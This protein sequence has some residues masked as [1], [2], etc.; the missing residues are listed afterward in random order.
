MKRSYLYVFYCTKANMPFDNETFHLGLFIMKPGT[1]TCIMRVPQCPSISQNW[2][3]HASVCYS[4]VITVPTP[5]QNGRH[6]KDIFKL[7]LSYENWCIFIW[8]SFKFISKAINNEQI[9]VHIINWRMA[10]RHVIIWSYILK[11]FT[12][13]VNIDSNFIEVWS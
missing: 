10:G 4:R 1:L 6:F 12:K 9:L 7:I 11:W 2:S 13:D 8:I 5:I 3:D